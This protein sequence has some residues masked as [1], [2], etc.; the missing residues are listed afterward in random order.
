MEGRRGFVAIIVLIGV[1]ILRLILAFDRSTTT[2]LIVLAVGFFLWLVAYTVKKES[3]DT[4]PD[5]QPKK[6]R[7]ALVPI[8]YEGKTY[9][10]V[11]DVP[12]EGRKGYYTFLSSLRKADPK[13]REML[14]TRI[15]REDVATKLQEA[16]EM[17]DA[18]LLTPE[19]Y[20]ETT[21]QILT[22]EE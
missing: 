22:P 1:V 14:L 16:Q 9:T 15:G 7:R 10:Y 21:D 8:K 18:G 13:G 6:K 4:L 12:Y 20:I 17:L 2:Y 5:P 3:Q 19:E 11:D